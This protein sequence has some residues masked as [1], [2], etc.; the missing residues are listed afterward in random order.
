MPTKN[1]I[2]VIISMGI[3]GAVSCNET[4]S[5]KAGTKE[6]SLRI[7]KKIAE[8][9]PV[10]LSKLSSMSK[11]ALSLEQTYITWDTVL[12]YKNDYDKNPL[13]CIEGKE[14]IKGF[15]VNKE[16]YKSMM[17]NTNIEGLYLRFGKKG[18]GTYTM[19]LLGTD[20][21]GNLLEMTNEVDPDQPRANFDHSSPCPTSCPPN[22]SE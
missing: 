9:Y 1:L 6:D 7:A 19:M 13:F 22:F 11:S 17:E 16:T 10:E 20:A 21:E 4:G 3:I 2:A 12:A 15:L 5:G 14:P 18:D 8:D